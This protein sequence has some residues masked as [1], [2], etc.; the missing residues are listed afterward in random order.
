MVR[1]KTAENEEDQR[2]QE[3][4]GKQEIP[5]TFPIKEELEEQSV[6]QEEEQMQVS[7]SESSAVCMKTEESS[8]GEDISSETLVHTQTEGDTGH[9]SGTDNDDDWGDPM[10]YSVCVQIPPL[11]P[12]PSLNQENP[13]T[14]QIKEEPEEP[15]VKQE[16]EQLQLGKKRS[17]V[18]EHF[19]LTKPN[20]VRC[21]LC[22]QV[23]SYTNNTSSM[24]RHLRARH[25][26]DQSQP[27]TTGPSNSGHYPDMSKKMLDEAIV[28]MIIK[29][30]Q[31]FSMVEGEGFTNLLKILDPLYKVPCH[32]TVKTMV[33]ERY[34]QK[35]KK[36]EGELKKASAVSLTAD[37]WTSR[38]MDAYLGVTCHYLS[39]NFELSTIL[40]GVQ[41]FPVTHTA[42]HIT[43]AGSTM[44]AEWG[45]ADKVCAMVT[46]GARN[47]V[48]S[49][50][51]LSIQNIHCFAH[52]LNHVVKKSISQTSE[53]DTMRSKAR[54]IVGH[55][56]SSCTAKK[57]LAITQSN[58][59][60]PQVKLVQEVET[61]WNS[62]FAMFQR[63]YEQREPLGAALASL[64]ST[65]NLTSFSAEDYDAIN[66]CL[67]VLRP[68]NQATAE[69]CGEARVL[70]SK[71]IPI[72]KMLT[73]AIT[74]EC[75]QMDDG[76]GAILATHLKNNV[77]EKMSGLEKVT[78]LSLATILDPRFKEVAFCSP[79]NAQA[80]VERLSRECASLIELRTQGEVQPQP[81][82]APSDDNNL[83]ALLDSH[84]VAQQTSRASHSA[85]EEIQRYLKE[86]HIP[87]CEDPLKYWESHKIQYPNLWR[88][89]QKYLCIPAS[90]VP[91]E[92]I[93]SKAGELVSRRRCRLKPSTVEKLLFLN[94][95]M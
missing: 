50:N 80:A 19:D 94:K 42:A 32:K 6:K 78:S 45:I 17:M 2:R 74:V 88:L 40:L 95:N 1:P 23:L 26:T 27:S 4:V 31:P 10:S 12:G 46:D 91:C 44:M 89:A 25:N 73:H 59:G 16:E 62:T 66:Q 33:E 38:N 11:S 47:I 9:S 3:L 15:S 52:L 67:K 29:D 43:E 53:L 24:L 90:S 65:S 60:M 21:M 35:K 55:F 61:R 7:V 41:Y 75:N 92:R 30:G 34:Q 84:V 81:S 49:V 79:S 39:D 56:K 5:E 8:Q 57:K 48:E 37:M 93:F 64:T 72:T 85:T 28:D 22:T 68:F 51:C 71:V 87:R 36:A 58:M 83:W 20:K 82:P 70:G 77:K 18:W 86:Q 63:M 14:L 13:G 76:V 54:K 69:L